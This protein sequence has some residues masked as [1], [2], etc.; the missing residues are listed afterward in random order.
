MSVS[1]TP[2]S[3]NLP[4]R[5]GTYIL[6]VHLTCPAV[7][8]VGRLGT[9]PLP[10]GMYAYCGSARGAGGLRARINRHLRLEKP[11]HWHIDGECSK[12]WTWC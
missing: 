1:G 2:P 3:V 4:G 10:A 12:R 11:I 6:L 8:S 7:L 9:Y 5:A